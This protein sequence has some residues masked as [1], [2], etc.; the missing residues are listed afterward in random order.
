MLH[1]YDIHPAF[2]EEKRR[3]NRTFQYLQKDLW[4]GVDGGDSIDGP[5]PGGLPDV[6]MQFGRWFYPHGL[7][8]RLFRGRRM[9]VF[10]SSPRFGESPNKKSITYSI[11]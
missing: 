10:T 9:H 4:H 2:P 11:N 3:E 6:R 1:R 8:G 7:E 5:I